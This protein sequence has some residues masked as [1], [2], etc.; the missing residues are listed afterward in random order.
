MEGPSQ[1]RSSRAARNCYP[2]GHTTPI[3]NSTINASQLVISSPRSA[4]S[5]FSFMSLQLP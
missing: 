4:N 3:A 1:W 2:G 5:D